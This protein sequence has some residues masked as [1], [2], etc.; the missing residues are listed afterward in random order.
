LVDKVRFS[1]KPDVKILEA[2]TFIEAT[3]VARMSEHLADEDFAVGSKDTCMIGGY[4]RKFIANL[5]T[6]AAPTG[7]MG[8]LLI[9]NE[10][11]WDITQQPD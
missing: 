10:N 1:G 8:H 5:L 11:R 7:A 4:C 3:T 2:D 9:H 6:F